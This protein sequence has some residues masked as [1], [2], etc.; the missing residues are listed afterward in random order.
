MKVKVTDRRKF[1]SDGHLLQEDPAAQEEETQAAAEGSAPSPP[2]PPPEREESAGKG[3]AMP[4][5]EPGSATSSAPAAGAA[6]ES[7]DRSE[8]SPPAKVDFQ[9]FVYFIYMSALQELGIPTQEGVD[10]R[11]ANLERARFFVDVLELLEGKTKGNLEP[12]EIK[13]LEEALYNLRLQ[14]LGVSKAMP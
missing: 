3:S 13:L 12:G 14:Y 10:P 11:P 6:S 9:S 4:A 8:A 5:A 1:S 2:E 7:S